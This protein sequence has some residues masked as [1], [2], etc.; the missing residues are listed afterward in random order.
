MIAISS[1]L[2]VQ[3]T[4]TFQI[5]GFTT[6]G[7]IALIAADQSIYNLGFKFTNAATNNFPRIHFSRIFTLPLGSD[8]TLVLPAFLQ[9]FS[10]T[11]T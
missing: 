11:R 4:Q 1:P 10:G 3:S 6:S 2:D 8:T 9:D 5:Y 7:N